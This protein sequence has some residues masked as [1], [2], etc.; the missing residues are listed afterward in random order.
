MSATVETGLVYIGLCPEC[1]ADSG[2]CNEESDAEA[3]AATHNAEN[4][5]EN[6]TTDEDYERFK[7][8]RDESC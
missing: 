3:W 1:S 4:H 5:G 8:S 6:G 2:P 7:E